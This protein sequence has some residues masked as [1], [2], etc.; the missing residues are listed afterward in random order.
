MSKA[1]Y[2]LKTMTI[3]SNTRLYNLRLF[4]VYIA[5]KE[6]A[7]NI[8]TTVVISFVGIV[9]PYSKSKEYWKHRQLENRT[10]ICVCRTIGAF[11]LYS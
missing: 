1:I 3:L 6:I 10:Q 4:R 5:R 11:Q 7:I 2:L 8:T 9:R